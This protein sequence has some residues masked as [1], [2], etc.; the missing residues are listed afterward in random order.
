[1]KTLLDRQAAKLKRLLR[2]RKKI[3]TTLR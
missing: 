1:M 3:T 2:E